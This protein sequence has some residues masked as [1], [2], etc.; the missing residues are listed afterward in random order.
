MMT[1][2]D[3]M[4]MA[5]HYIPRDL[6]L[7]GKY[8]AASRNDAQVFMAF[9]AFF[10]PFSIMP[11]DIGCS[12]TQTRRHSIKGMALTI[13]KS[14]I[15]TTAVFCVALFGI[16]DPYMEMQNPLQRYSIWSRIEIVISTRGSHKP[17]SNSFIIFTRALRALSKLWLDGCD[18]AAEMKTFSASPACVCVIHLRWQPSTVQRKHV[19]MCRREYS[20][21]PVLLLVRNVTLVSARPFDHRVTTGKQSFY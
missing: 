1:T 13:N 11:K 8:A 19:Q 16:R 10:V 12:R 2:Y 7:E 15:H 9:A 18:F 21:F 5:Q 3:G 4:A 20:V 6:F 14:T 17:Q